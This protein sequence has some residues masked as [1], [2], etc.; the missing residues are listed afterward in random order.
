ML[1]IRWGFNLSR[2]M[3]LE[4]YFFS[5]SSREWINNISIITF[6]IFLLIIL[7][8][9]FLILGIII[10]IYIRIN[11]FYLFSRLNIRLCYFILIIKRAD[12]GRETILNDLC[13]KIFILIDFLSLLINV[14]IIER[15]IS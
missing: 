1:Y 5:T 7:L 15:L 3:C 12:D 4:V 13:K 9:F 8:L 2:A 14:E 11:Y 10:I 6:V